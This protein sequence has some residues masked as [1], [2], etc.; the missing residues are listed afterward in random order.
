MLHGGFDPGLGAVGQGDQRQAHVF[1]AFAQK[2]QAV[3][4]A[5]KTRLKEDR[6]VQGEKPVLVGQRLFV[7]TCQRGCL[8]LGAKT[9]GDVGGD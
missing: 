5:R 2:R 1:A 9:R 7:I 6:L 8:K 4:C 3:F